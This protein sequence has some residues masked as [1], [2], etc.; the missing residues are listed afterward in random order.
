MWNTLERK[1]R[2]HKAVQRSFTFTNG[3]SL[4]CLNI[5][6]TQSDLR[7]QDNLH[8]NINGILHRPRE[9]NL[10]FSFLWVN[11]TQ[12]FVFDTFRQINGSTCLH[13]K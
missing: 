4:C 11:N 8:Q 7:I 5:Y 13:V 6:A 3:K 2:K 1:W 9:I 10:Y 12:L